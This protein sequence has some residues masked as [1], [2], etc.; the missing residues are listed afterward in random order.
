MNLSSK[1]DKQKV[2][3]ASLLI[4]IG[5]SCRITLHDFFNSIN[6]PFATSG[7]LDVF[8]IIALISIFS[9]ILL[10]KYYTFII[11]LCVIGIT[12][13]FYGI[14][15]PINTALWSTW[16]F[17]FTTTGYIFIALIGLYNRKNSKFNMSFIPKIL[18]SGIFAI[19][20]YDL[21]TNFGFWLSYSKLGFYP[22]TISGLIT[23]YIGGLPF[24]LW[25]ILS[26]SIALTIILIPIIHF[27]NLSKISYDII[28]K[29]NE[30]IYILSATL[31][32]ITASII[33]AII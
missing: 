2:T 18:G 26:F 3:I 10:G 22:Q 11:P 16:L 15:D 29:P 33:T 6:N 17:L 23:V 13:I 20:I 7:Y 8:F 27:K 12:D 4:I 25:H 28:L 5:V 19:I 14:I 32:L 9:G 24:M 30:K 21:W 1:F 31:I